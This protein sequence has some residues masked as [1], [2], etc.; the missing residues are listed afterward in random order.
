MTA[1][2]PDTDCG[3]AFRLPASVTI[4]GARELKAQLLQHLE[5]ATLSIELGDVREVDTAGVQLLLALRTS[6]LAG[7]RSLRWQGDIGVVAVAAQSLGLTTDLGLA[8]GA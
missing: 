8:G 5:H 2:D 7:G 4:H 3:A 6:C 1:T